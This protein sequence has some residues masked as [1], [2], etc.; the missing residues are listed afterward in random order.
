MLYCIIPAVTQVAEITN[1][2]EEVKANAT[3][4]SQLIDARSQANY[5]VWFAPSHI[6]RNF[7]NITTP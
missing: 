1:E 4:N 5:Q 3:A 2:A 7:T 6:I